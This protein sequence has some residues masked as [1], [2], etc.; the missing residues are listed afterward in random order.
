MPSQCP[1]CTSRMIAPLPTPHKIRTLVGAV[2]QAVRGASSTIACTKPV[3]GITLAVISDI[4]LASIEGRATAPIL[5]N[6]K[7]QLF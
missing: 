2:S 4:I 5:D 1:R 3:L 6:R 7:T